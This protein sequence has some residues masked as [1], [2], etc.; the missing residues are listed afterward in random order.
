M[1][2]RTLLLL[3]CLLSGGVVTPAAASDE[4]KQLY[5]K[6]CAQCHGVNGD[7]K[8]H[9][10]PR[11]K[12]LPRDFTS[13]KYKFRTT[14]SGALPTDADLT[15]VIK[16]GLPYTSMPDWPHSAPVAS[17]SRPAR[18]GRRSTRAARSS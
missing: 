16:D 2:A 11:V 8:G 14:P 13:G 6:Y 9:A 3:T 7:G 15:K 4:G 10:T 5:D 17:A 12:P 1:R 18:S